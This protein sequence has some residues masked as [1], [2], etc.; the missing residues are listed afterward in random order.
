MDLS[1]VSMFITFTV[2][3]A[4]ELSLWTLCFIRFYF[5]LFYFLF[6]GLHFPLIASKVPDNIMELCNFNYIIHRRKH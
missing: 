2:H 5:I 6:W 1:V 4:Y 3:F